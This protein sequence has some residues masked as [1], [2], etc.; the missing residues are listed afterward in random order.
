MTNSQHVVVG[1]PY[2][3]GPTTF[4]FWSKPISMVIM[5]WDPTKFSLFLSPPNISVVCCTS[6]FN[7][8]LRGGFHT[9]CFTPS[10]SQKGSSCGS[11]AIYGWNSSRYSVN[12]HPGSIFDRWWLDLTGEHTIINFFPSF[13]TSPFFQLAYSNSNTLTLPHMTFMPLTGSYFIYML[14]SLAISDVV[15]PDTQRLFFVFDGWIQWYGESRTKSFTTIVTYLPHFRSVPFTSPH[16]LHLTS[17]RQRHK[18]HILGSQAILGWNPS[19]S[20]VNPWRIFIPLTAVL[21]G[22]KNRM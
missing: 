9:Q 12:P 18:V 10:T 20:A 7:Q 1:Q 2:L 5:V 11:L 6:L 4:H 3:L 8:I 21:S 19:W 13:W 17:R 14:S 15:H 22:P 16:R